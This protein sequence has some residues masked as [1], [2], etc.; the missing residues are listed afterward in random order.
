MGDKNERIRNLVSNMNNVIKGLELE[1]QQKKNDVEKYINENKE[2][3][4]KNSNLN[5]ALKEGTKNF[6]ISG[7]AVHTQLDR[8]SEELTKI[9]TVNDAKDRE[10]KNFGN[11]LRVKEAE[12]KNKN[13]MIEK[14]EKDIQTFHKMQN[15]NRRKYQNLQ[16]K[17]N[18]LSN[19]EK[20]S[21]EIAKIKPTPLAL[22]PNIY[23]GTYRQGDS[24]VGKI[25]DEE[26]TKKEAERVK[27][28][29]PLAGLEG[30]VK[31][32]T[33]A[34]EKELEK[35]KLKQGDFGYVRS[36][37]ELLRQKKPMV[38]IN[39]GKR[40]SKRRNK[41]NIRRTIKNKNR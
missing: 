11:Q 36:Q 30:N 17:V 4:E 2:L 35:T 33:T 6:E 14:I 15:E 7:Q 5:T 28:E 29:D 13:E 23:D 27:E 19:S 8:K 37:A 34:I 22:A 25:S 39:G 3:L 12:L 40:K 26:I 9:K 20:S 16:S 41:K 10:I 31:A 32:R 38:P 18:H 24:E 1:L 21:E